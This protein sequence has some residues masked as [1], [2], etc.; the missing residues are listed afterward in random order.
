MNG[1]MKYVAVGL[2]AL[3]LGACETTQQS[4]GLLDQARSACGSA[5]GFNG[6]VCNDYVALATE[7]SN[8]YADYAADYADADYYSQKA[9]VAGGGQTV[10]PT[11][12]AE[13]T[14]PADIIAEVTD[15]RSRLMAQFDAGKR[16]TKPDTAATAQTMYDCWLEQLEEGYQPQ[17]IARCRQGFLDALAELERRE[18]VAPPVIPTAEPRPE[19]FLVFF[20]FDK[21]DITPESANVIRQAA[22]RAKNAGAASIQV[23]GHADRSGSTAYNERLSI[24]RANAVRDELARNGIS[25]GDVNVEGRGESDPLV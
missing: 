12:V 24:R 15:G 20:D 17:D 6:A 19:P 14:L 23:I 3:A 13:R 11:E 16:E 1:L 22:D 7:E 4:S 25:S 2:G 10:L 18:V 5:S 8:P 21:S 9:I